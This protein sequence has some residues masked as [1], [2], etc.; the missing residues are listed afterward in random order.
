MKIPIV[1]TFDDNYALPA[2]VAIK[3]L[4]HTGKKETW[5]D[6]YVLYQNLSDA[7]RRALDQVA[8]IN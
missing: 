1:F 4:V 8:K 2:A 7:N 3:S 6:I 5:Y